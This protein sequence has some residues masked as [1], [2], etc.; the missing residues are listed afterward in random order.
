MLAVPA[1]RKDA[2]RISIQ[3]TILPVHDDT[4]AMVGI[5]AFLRDV[6]TRF[7]ELRALRQ[8]LAAL[9]AQSSRE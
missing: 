6:T 2:K 3:F 4:G 1:M 7:N 5:A 9:R 8:E